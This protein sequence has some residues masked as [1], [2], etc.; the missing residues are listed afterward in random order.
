MQVKNV[1]RATLVRKWILSKIKEH[2]LE[3]AVERLI[4]V[5]EGAK[6]ACTTIWKF[7]EYIHEKTYGHRSKLKKN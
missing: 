7:I 4:S 3:K 6:V 5:E 2:K 1:D